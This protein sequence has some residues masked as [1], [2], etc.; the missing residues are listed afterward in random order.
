MLKITS[1]KI[2]LP[3]LEKDNSTPEQWEIYSKFIGHMRHVPVS[4][5]EIKIL[6]AIQFCADMIDCSDAHIAKELVDMGLRAPRIAFPMEFLN[7]VDNSLT[8]HDWDISSPSAA[9]L[10]LRDM[11]L[12][13]AHQLNLSPFRH[14]H[15]IVKEDILYQS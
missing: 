3:Y 8:R 12:S 14:V 1:D 7:F 4:R 2:T 10:D 15:N 11:W 13:G 6:S 9:L 5:A